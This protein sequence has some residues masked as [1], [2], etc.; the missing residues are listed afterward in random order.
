MKFVAFTKKH[1]LY[2]SLIFKLKVGAVEDQ[3]KPWY[4]T[5]YIS[6]RLLL[7]PVYVKKSKIQLYVYFPGV[8]DFI[9]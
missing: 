2:A 1:E 6:W 5:Q 7:A 9:F 4:L 8:Y 3:A